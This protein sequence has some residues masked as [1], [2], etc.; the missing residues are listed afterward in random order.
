ML[1][2][3]NR[4]LFAVRVGDAALLV[5]RSITAKSMRFQTLP[6][7]SSHAPSNA[8]T[9][10]ST[11]DSSQVMN[12]LGLP[13]R[14]FDARRFSSLSPL[15]AGPPQRFVM[16]HLRHPVVGFRPGAFGQ[17]LAVSRILGVTRAWFCRLSASSRIAWCPHA[18]IGRVWKTLPLPRGKTVRAAC[19]KNYRPK[20]TGWPATAGHRQC[21]R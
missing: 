3:A 7:S 2:Q 11:L 15:C 9:T 19:P 14:C 10:S 20:R 8:R 6:F 12:G 16:R 5:R 17:D 18:L 1:G 4:L 21:R 13:V